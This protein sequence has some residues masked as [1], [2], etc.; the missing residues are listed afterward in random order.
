V[1]SVLFYA[2]ETWKTTNQI[3]RRLQTF[4]NKCLRQIM[5]IKW[6]DKITNEELWRITKTKPIEIQTKSRKR[7][8]LGCTLRKEA[9]AIEKTTLDW[10]SQ[11]YRR[12]GRP[13]RMWQRTIEYEIRNTG[14]SWNEVKGIATDH[15]A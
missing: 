4:I 9:G 15:N 11:G 12:R 10:N 7:N 1:K 3:T 13:K 14:R 6:T 2:C 8:W 5:N